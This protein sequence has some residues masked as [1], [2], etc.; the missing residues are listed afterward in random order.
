M[1][2]VKFISPLEDNNDN[3]QEEFKITVEPLENNKVSLQQISANLTE[4]EITSTP[5]A[6]SQL[7]ARKVIYI[8]DKI[9]KNIKTLLVF[10][11]ILLIPL[12]SIATSRRSKPCL[13]Q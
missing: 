10:A 7:E 11:I 2:E 8:Q 3:Y 13:P 5:F 4:T 1:R 12:P 6:V 9:N